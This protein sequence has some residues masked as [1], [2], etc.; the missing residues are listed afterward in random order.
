MLKTNV[1]KVDGIYAFKDI[2]GDQFIGRVISLSDTDIVVQ[3][4]CHFANPGTGFRFSLSFKLAKDGVVPL[5]RQN[6]I[7]NYQVFQSLEDAYLKFLEE[8]D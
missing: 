2:A 7:T 4:P 6:I 3:F 8:R 1:I 5:K